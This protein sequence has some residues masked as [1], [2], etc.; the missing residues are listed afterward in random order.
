MSGDTCALYIKYVG[1]TL[2]GVGKVDCMFKNRPDISSLPFHTIAKLKISFLSEE[3]QRELQSYICL[4]FT[5]YV[6]VNAP[7]LNLNID[8]EI[9]AT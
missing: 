6:D 7:Y 5:D 9:T 4:K 2:S 8:F 1:C 3:P